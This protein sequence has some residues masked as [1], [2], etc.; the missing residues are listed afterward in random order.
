MTIDVA[1]SWPRL[2]LKNF[3]TNLDY[4]KVFFSPMRICRV[5]SASLSFDNFFSYLLVDAA[6][7][8]ETEKNS[9][10]SRITELK[11]DLQLAKESNTELEQLKKSYK[12]LEASGKAH[13]KELTR[14]LI[15]VAQG[16]SGDDSTISIRVSYFSVHVD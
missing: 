4:T 16:L 6:V 12:E 2:K 9:A 8:A 3:V 10:F 7:V 11:K 15:P 5:I 1:W 14:L 13:D